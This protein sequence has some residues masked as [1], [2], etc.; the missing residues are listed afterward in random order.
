MMISGPNFELRRFLG[1]SIKEYLFLHY[2]VSSS[3]NKNSGWVTITQVQALEYID[4]SPRTMSRLV[5]ALSDKRL[6][7]KKS[8]T[9]SSYRI[10]DLLEE[11]IADKSQWQ[12]TCDLYSSWDEVIEGATY[13]KMAEDDNTASAKMAETYAKMAEDT[14]YIE[15]INNNTSKIVSEKPTQ[16][17][18]GVNQ[19]SNSDST[20]T[21]KNN[22]YQEKNELRKN[23]LVLVRR[24]Q[25]V[26]SGQIERGFLTH[27]L[28][29]EQRIGVKEF[30]ARV[31]RLMADDFHRKNMGS[32]KYAYQRIK[33][34]ER[35][36]ATAEQLATVVST[37]QYED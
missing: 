14:I 28:S 37:R 30:E 5:K 22:S 21:S 18:T 35:I 32:L 25:F 13:A 2:I 26:E 24:D 27:L 1:I 15:T 12:L 3:R 8:R 16:N 20:F 17:F 31:R 34:S 6:I 29:L 10:T 7:E 36:T 4:A 23:L 11:K 33:G 9:A 19:A